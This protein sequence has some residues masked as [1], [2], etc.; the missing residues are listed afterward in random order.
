MM[1]EGC[2][3]GGYNCLKNDSK[4]ISNKFS[5]AKIV[6]LEQCFVFFVGKFC[7]VEIFFE[8]RNIPK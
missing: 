5:L 2:Q 7:I 6:S 4:M 8:K 1:R 3:N